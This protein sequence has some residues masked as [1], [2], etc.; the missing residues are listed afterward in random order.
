M[1]L[2]R[3]LANAKEQINAVDTS[4]YLRELDPQELSQLQNTL[5]EML[6]E[7]L[8][9]CKKHR[10]RIFLL[11]GTA[12]GAVRHEGFIPWDDD[13]DVGMPREDYERFIPAFEKEMSDRYI[14][15]AP[16]YSKTVLARFPKILKKDSYLDDGI[17]E[18]KDLSKVFLDIFIT[19]GIP[20]N[21]LLRRWKG[22]RCNFMEFVAGQVAY[23]E[24]LDEEELFDYST[25]SQPHV[26]FLFLRNRLQQ[27]HPYVKHIWGNCLL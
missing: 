8:A 21:G 24:Y 18:D 14:L 12:L 16:N 5:L 4:S 1:K 22:F 6:L 15:N 10:I 23:F 11:G 26:R 9:V 19:D 7:L 17:R 2:I 27:N 13:V 25:K 3:Q 20:E